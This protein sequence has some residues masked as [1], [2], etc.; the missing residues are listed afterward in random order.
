MKTG[1]LTTDIFT[2]GDLYYAQKGDKVQ[3]LSITPEFAM[4]KYVCGIFRS[5]PITHTVKV[6]AHRVKVATT[7]TAP[8][9]FKK[10]NKYFIIP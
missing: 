6:Y 10:A 7:P 8:A 4:L 3:V 9:P 2:P 5:K 1:I